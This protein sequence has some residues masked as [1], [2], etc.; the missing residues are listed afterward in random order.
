MPGTLPLLSRHARIPLLVA[1]LA[2][3]VPAVEPAF[4]PILGTA[5]TT[6]TVT[7]HGFVPVRKPRVDFLAS[8]PEQEG[9]A[10]AKARVLSYSESSI[11]AET[12]RL[13]PGTYAILV[14]PR[15][16]EGE[17]VLLPGLFEVSAP[18]TESV[19]VGSVAAGAPFSLHGLFGDRKGKVYVGTRKAKVQVWTNDRI[20]AEVPRRLPPGPLPFV[21]RNGTGDSPQAFPPEAPVP[22]PALG[23][24]RTV[25]EIQI[26]QNCARTFTISNTGDQGTTLA[27]SVADDGALGGFLQ[28]GTTAGNVGT[29]FQ[30]PVS[31]QVK[32]EFVSS[33]PSLAGADLVLNVYTPGASNFV[34]FPVSVK[35][36]SAAQVAQR[37]VGTWSGTWSGS[38]EGPNNPMEEKPQAAVSGTWS[39]SIEAVD[40]DAGQFTGSLTWAGN[41]VYWTY[42]LDAGG[43]YINRTAVAFPGTA[44]VV[45]ITA[46]KGLVQVPGPQCSRFRVE[47]RGSLGA[48]NPSDA[49][50][51]P[52]FSFD[53]DTESGTVVPAT[54]LF[55]THPYNPNGNQ[56]WA[57]RGT[58]D[59]GKQ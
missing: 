54:T 56:T 10:D 23:L 2:G 15:G 42:D 41:D 40:L 13:V 44:R 53:V 31:V 17:P 11:L 47:V 37:L 39:L 32:P 57:S 30:A 12:P 18:Y 51:G 28:V 1:L 26:P 38:C 20:D 3:A 19:E 43:A 50:Y 36:R 5:G 45:S 14:T 46:G 59:G 58:M 21:V 9:T 16:G 6:V 35:I 27:F 33:E 55:T 22:A 24:D 48:A 34:K 7:G 49:F 8:P 29:G 52:D 25:I 4:S